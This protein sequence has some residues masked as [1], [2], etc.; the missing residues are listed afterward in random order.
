MTNKQDILSSVCVLPINI[1]G[2]PFQKCPW[3]S[4]ISSS[5]LLTVK[6]VIFIWFVHQQHIKITSIIQLSYIGHNQLFHEQ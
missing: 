3:T 1:S 2:C 4:G 5:N 6:H